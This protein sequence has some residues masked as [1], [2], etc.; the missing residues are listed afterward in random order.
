[1]SSSPGPR[2]GGPRRRRAFTARE[3]LD[4]LTAYEA[5][6]AA[7]DGGGAYLR[8]QG[9]Y[10][11]QIT[12][13][14]KLRDAWVLARE[15]ARREDRPPVGGAGRDRPAHPGVGLD[16]PAFGENR[17]ST[18]SS[19]KSTRSLGGVLRES[20]HRERAEETLTGCYDDLV[21]AGVRTRDAAALMGLS[22]ATQDRRRSR[23]RVGPPADPAARPVP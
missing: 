19:G 6:C 14:R 17:S 4:H 9:V 18:G 11:S 10:S 5:A 23:H 1:M 3:K 2:E 8:E 22:K 13:W 21:T 16:P 7:G 12:E 20:G 15:E